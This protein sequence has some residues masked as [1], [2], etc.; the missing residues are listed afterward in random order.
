M[1]GI[2]AAPLI[3]LRSPRCGHDVASSADL[4]GARMPCMLCATHRR[5]AS[6]RRYKANPGG[7]QRDSGW[8]MPDWPCRPSAPASA[9][10]PSRAA[11]ASAIAS[12]ASSSRV[13][14]HLD[15][16]CFH[17]GP[18]TIPPAVSGHSRAPVPGRS[19]RPRA[20]RRAVT[21]SWGWRNPGGRLSHRSPGTRGSHPT[22]LVLPRW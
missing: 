2:I 7:C 4:P 6:L 18:A 11:P 9:V 22:A 13:Q 5:R 12:S 17:R 10:H 1:P 21:S 16:S 3:R 8:T 14:G 19:T 20:S 15:R